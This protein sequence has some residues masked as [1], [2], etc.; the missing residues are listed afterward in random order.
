V[1]FSRNFAPLSAE[2]LVFRSP[3]LD[4]TRN[5][6]ETFERVCQNTVIGAPHPQMI[7]DPTEFKFE[8]L[9]SVDVRWVICALL[10]LLI[11]KSQ[12]KQRKTNRYHTFTI[13]NT[14]QLRSVD[15]T[16]SLQ[17]QKPSLFASLSLP[18]TKDCVVSSV[19]RLAFS[20]GF[21]LSILQAVDHPRTTAHAGSH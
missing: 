9:V 11:C 20:S 6:R 13:A 21:T 14:Q 8:A 18:N 4:T 1:S 19:F 17:P 12:S 5:A 3:H 2:S 15:T 7:T 10:A 16:R